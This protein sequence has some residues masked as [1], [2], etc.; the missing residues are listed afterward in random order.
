MISDTS[1][2]VRLTSLDAF[3]QQKLAALDARDRRRIPVT[4][5]HEGHPYVVRDAHHLIS[6]SGNDY[7][8]LTAHPAVRGAATEAIRR[9]GTGAGGAYLLTGRHPLYA[10]LEAALAAFK[11]TEDAC[12]FGSG[13]LANAGTAASL[14]GPGDLVLIDER[15]HASMWAGARASG[16]QVVAFAHNDAERLREL[17][18]QHRARYERALVMTEGVFSMDGDRAPLGALDGCARAYDAWLYVDD[19]HGVGVLGGGRGSCAI[20]DPPPVVPLQMGTLSKALASY[21]GYVCASAAVVALLRNRAR[22]FV[23]STALPPA[24]VAAAL[25]A[26]EVLKSE[27]ERV[28][29][30][31]VLARHFAAQAGLPE[32]ESP[33]VPL[34]IGAERDALVFA[35]ALEAAGFLA[36]AIRPPTVPE[37]TARLRFTFSAVHTD[38]DVSRLAATVRA[39][40]ATR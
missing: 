16:A 37:G 9:Y 5:Y 4:T 26:L 40:R 29:R 25:A 18:V 11:G 2:A 19:A 6:F 39:L 32:P 14:A 24:S 8:G 35:Q 34:V 15:A 36:V 38:D 13:F 1:A 20:G 12:V 31:L 3:A 22:T 30:P 21:G 7:L 17:L 27:P 23:Y 10:E 28:A 33:I